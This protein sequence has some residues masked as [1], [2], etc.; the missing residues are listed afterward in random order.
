MSHRVS[1]V[2]RG[3][4]LDQVPERVEQRVAFSYHRVRVLPALL[5]SVCQA[6]PGRQQVARCLLRC[7]RS[8]TAVAAFGGKADTKT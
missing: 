7:I 5:S 4:T 1:G 6:R 8:R 2:Y 3:A